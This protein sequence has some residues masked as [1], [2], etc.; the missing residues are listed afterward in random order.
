LEAKFEKKKALK[1]EIDVTQDEI[2]QK[3]NR[4]RPYCHKWNEDILEELKVEPAN[5]KLR[6]YKSK[7][8]KHVTRKNNN[9]I[10]NNA[11]L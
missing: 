6:R 3:T 11:E 8:L 2:L 10:K 9:N 5:D 4:L 1:K 7:C